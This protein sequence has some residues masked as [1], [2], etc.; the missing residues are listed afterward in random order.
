MSEDERFVAD[1]KE[2]WATVPY[3]GD[4]NITSHPCF[5]CEEIA[6]YFRGK[7]PWDN[8]PIQELRY[9]H[10]ALSLFTPAAHHYFL[11]AFILADLTDRRE[12]DV[13]GEN[14]LYGFANAPTDEWLAPRLRLFTPFQKQ[15]IWKYLKKSN[16]DQYSEDY[17]AKARRTLGVEE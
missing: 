13:I 2:A 9:H 15:V 14:I 16:T 17:V 12:A 3:P 7:S 5:E 1:L 11:P 4:N 8:F 6:E 10:A